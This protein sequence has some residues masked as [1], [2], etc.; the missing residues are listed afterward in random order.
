MEI[1]QDLIR[2]LPDLTNYLKSSNGE[3]LGKRRSNSELRTSMLNY[4]FKQEPYHLT[5]GDQ[6]QPIT[7]IICV[8]AEIPPN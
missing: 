2:F 1:K 7:R 6:F 3:G 8:L 4:V 5:R